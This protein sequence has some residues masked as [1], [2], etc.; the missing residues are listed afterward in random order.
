MWTY[1][2]GTKDKYHPEYVPV[3]TTTTTTVGRRSLMI[4]FRTDRPPTS[5]LELFE[6]VF[7]VQHFHVIVRCTGQEAVDSIVA[8][9]GYDKLILFER[10][11]RREICVTAASC[12]HT[13]SK[14]KMCST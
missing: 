12:Y 9:F 8:R 5:I 13:L 4:K 7:V 6:D 11:W 2:C 3:G 10:L 1:V 14:G